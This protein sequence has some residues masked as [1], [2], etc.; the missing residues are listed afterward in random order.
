VAISVEGP[1]FMATIGLLLVP[2][3]RSSSILVQVAKRSA[4]GVKGCARQRKPSCLGSYP[5]LALA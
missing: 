5:P 3:A 1:N 4:I 2:R